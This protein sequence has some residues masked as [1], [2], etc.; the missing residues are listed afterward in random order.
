MRLNIS[1]ETGFHF[2]VHFLI[3]PRIVRWT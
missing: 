2:L 3:H 1:Q